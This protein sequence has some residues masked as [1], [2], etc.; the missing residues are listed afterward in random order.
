MFNFA[1][2][3]NREGPGDKNVFEGG[4]L[5]LDN[6]AP[7]DRSNLPAGYILEQS[8]ATGWMGSYALAMASIAA[9]LGWSGRRQTRDLVL[10]FLEHTAGIRR[11]LDAQGLWD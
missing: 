4:F 9:I 5:G 1:W 2:W 8:D 3:V 7:I 10:K 6:I 11:A